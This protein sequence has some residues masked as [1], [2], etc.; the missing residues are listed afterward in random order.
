MKKIGLIWALIFVIVAC[1]CM[2]F[3]SSKKLTPENPAG[4][5]I[6]YTMVTSSGEQNNNERYVYEVIAYNEKGKE[7][8]LSFS[9]GKPLRNGAYVELYH[10]LLRGVTHW[11]EVAYADLPETVKQKYQK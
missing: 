9:A 8:K 6:F 4:K 11:K 1:L 2:F 10:T 3:F 5:T 7:K